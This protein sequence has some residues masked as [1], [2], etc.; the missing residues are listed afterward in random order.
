MGFTI[1]I[2]RKAFPKWKE[3]R[4]AQELPEKLDRKLVSVGT[5]IKIEHDIRLPDIMRH[6]NRFFADIFETTHLDQQRFP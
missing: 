6:T 2:N 3:T 5:L 1:E 4:I